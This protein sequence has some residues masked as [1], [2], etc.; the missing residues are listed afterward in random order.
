[1]SVTRSKWTA[2]VTRHVN[3]Q[4]HTFC[5][6]VAWSARMVSGPAKSTPVYEKAGSS[7]TRKVGRGSGDGLLRGLPQIFC[8][9]YNGESST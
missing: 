1:M 9:E 3:R 6:L 2:R 7:F 4:I 8:R 5:E